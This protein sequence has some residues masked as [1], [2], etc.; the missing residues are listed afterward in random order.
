M[1]ELRNKKCPRCRCWRFPKEFISNDR[2]LKTCDVCREKNKK[3][4]KKYYENNKEEIIEKQKQYYQTNKEEILQYQEQYHEKTKK[5]K[6]LQTKLKLMIR[7]STQNDKKNNRSINEDKYI[8]IDFLNELWIQQN[9]TCF[10]EDCNVDLDYE[11]FD[12]KHKKSNLL[13]IQRHNNNIS[14]DQSN[15]CFACFDCNC[16]KHKEREQ[17]NSLLQASESLTLQ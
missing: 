11:T 15:V 9:G 10:Y 8:N 7:N 2:L 13:T 3:S 14:H 4:T 6:P 5:N 12:K 1:A 17:Y 16:N